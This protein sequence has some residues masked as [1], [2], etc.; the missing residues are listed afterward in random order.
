MGSAGGSGKYKLR[1]ETYEEYDC[2]LSIL[3]ILCMVHLYLLVNLFILC[4]LK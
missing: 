3:G 2:I 4:F 1:D